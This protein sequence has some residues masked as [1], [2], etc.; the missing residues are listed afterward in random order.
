M[1]D[2]NWKDESGSEEQMRDHANMMARLVKIY[3]EE[4][5]KIGLTREEQLSATVAI[6]AAGLK[7]Q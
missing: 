5:Q 4:F 3:M 2:E 7:A 6:V 1:S